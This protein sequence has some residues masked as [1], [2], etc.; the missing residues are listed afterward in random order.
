[1]KAD[2][3]TMMLLVLRTSAKCTLNFDAVM[4]V[5]GKEGV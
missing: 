3:P 5:L 4:T 2:K 1:M